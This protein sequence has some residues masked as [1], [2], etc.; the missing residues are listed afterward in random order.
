M[1]L[2][3]VSRLAIA[4]ALVGGLSAAVTACK[5]RDKAAKSSATTAY[6]MPDYTPPATAVEGLNVGNIAPDIQQK[7]PTDSI[8]PLYSLRGKL[9]LIDFWAS[10]CGPC[11]QENPNVV[12]TYTTY[13]DSVFAGAQEGFTVYGVSLDKNKEGWTKAIAN[14]KLIWPYHVSDL[15]F[16]NNAAAVRYGVRSI[17]TNVLVDGNGVILAKNLRGSALS[18]AIRTQLETDR[19]K[20]N[21]VLKRRMSASTK[22]GK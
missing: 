5:P 6:P 2:N 11:R 13:K 8:I 22:S 9:V 15:G 7:N 19:A 21:A 18:A 12:Q 16:W 4:A 20:V 14:D 1:L 10:W 3:T 17:P